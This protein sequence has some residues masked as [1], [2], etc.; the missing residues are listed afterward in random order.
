VTAPSPSPRCARCG[1]RG[2]EGWS[3]PMIHISASRMVELFPDKFPTIQSVGFDDE[4][5][6]KAGGHAFV[7]PAPTKPG[8]GT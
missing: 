1:Q 2:G 5:W 7:P 8:G 3:D 4:T 6:R